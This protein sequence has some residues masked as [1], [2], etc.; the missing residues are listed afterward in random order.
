[1]KTEKTILVIDDTQTDVHTLVELLEDNYDVLAS[2]SGK[3]GLKIL[4]EETVDLI[5]LDIMMPE[6]DGL[7]VCKKLQENPKTKLIPVIFITALMDEHT[8]DK[9]FEVGGVDYITKPFRAQE[10]ASRVRMHLHFS[11]KLKRVL[12][13]GD[14]S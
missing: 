11:K 6:M 12:A 13:N 9:A 3:E 14:D 2:L 4:E 10:V 1:M 7:E 8:I 5:L